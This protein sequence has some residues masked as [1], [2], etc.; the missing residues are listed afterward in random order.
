MWAE[1]SDRLPT[2]MKKQFFKF[3][4]EQESSTRR[5]E[6]EEEVLSALDRNASSSR[7]NGYYRTA[8]R[9]YKW[10]KKDRK[11]LLDLI[12]EYK[13]ME[14]N[15]RIPLGQENTKLEEMQGYKRTEKGKVYKT[16]AS[17]LERRAKVK[18]QEAY[19]RIA[20]LIPWMWT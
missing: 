12:S 13:K 14:K 8:Y 18:D 2:V 19:E 4:E 5:A 9:V 1:P 20:K 10:F 17:R 16:K 11:R 3:V 7:S 6:T 15:Q